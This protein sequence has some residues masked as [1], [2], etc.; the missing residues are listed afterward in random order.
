MGPRTQ[1][2]D[3]VPQEVRAALAAPLLLLAS[4]CAAARPSGSDGDPSSPE[5][6]VAS[7]GEERVTKAALADFVYAR[8]REAWW[9]S[10][11]DLVDE[12][13]V[14]TEAARL[15][16]RVPPA[17][18]DAAVE[19]EAKARE[20]DLKARLG[21]SADLPSSV[22]AYYGLDV[23]AWKRDV[24]RPRLSVR[25]ALER[26]VRLSSRLR[27]RV[28]ARVIVV[29]DLA[30]AE[31]LREKILRGADF[32]LT[33]LE[34]SIDPSRREGGVL[35][36]ISRGDLPDAV[37]RPLFVAAPGSIVGPLAVE[38]AGGT[39]VH[40]YKVIAREPPWAGEPA[41]LAARLEED[42]VAK[43]VTAAEHERWAVRTRRE[44]GVRWYAPDGTLLPGPGR[45]R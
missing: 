45:G 44:K 43:P 35:P 15:G 18:L 17:I 30:K 27:E 6:P 38:G 7:V 42:L 25:L 29:R 37:E 19:A 3:A 8:F 28:E 39:E 23:E 9:Q 4:A 12:R 24:L 5:A 41:T 22:R 13:L 34:A 1:R 11:A 31:A 2:L 10:V 36:P 16:V 26:V 14:A 40:L 21:E 32:S 20:R 33:A